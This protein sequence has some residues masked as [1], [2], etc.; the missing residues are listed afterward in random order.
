MASPTTDA[1]RGVVLEVFRTGGQ[2]RIREELRALERAGELAQETDVTTQVDAGD[3]D[4]SA[5]LEIDLSDKDAELADVWGE[6]AMASSTLDGFNEA[7]PIADE[8]TLGLLVSAEGLCEFRD[9]EFARVYSPRSGW[10]KLRLDELA[11]RSLVLSSLADW[12]SKHRSEFLRSKDLWDFGPEDLEEAKLGCAALQKGILHLADLRGQGGKEL[13]RESL[14][15]YLVRCEFCWHDGQHAPISV[16]FSRDACLA[17][18]AKAVFIFI[19]R[20]RSRNPAFDP[21]T[22]LD[23]KSVEAATPRTDADPDAMTLPEFAKWACLRADKVPWNEVL[24][25]HQERLLA[26]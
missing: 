12:L 14:S 25:R 4:E 17:W 7:S 5:D 23:P 16:M 13:K 19:N 8:D 11:T 10:A 26:L 2:Q 3:I 9:L 22:G 21:G 18:V 15:R 20:I 24:G 1:Q 6:S